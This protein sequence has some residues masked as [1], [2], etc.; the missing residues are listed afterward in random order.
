M[1]LLVV[2]RSSPLPMENLHSTSN[3]LEALG[4]LV[5]VEG[6]GQNLHIFKINRIRLLKVPNYNN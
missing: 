2:K 1:R 5:G 4:A 3:I 6:V